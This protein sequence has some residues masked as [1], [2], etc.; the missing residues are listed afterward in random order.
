MVLMSQFCK[1]HTVAR[2]LRFC[3]TAVQ[4][5]LCAFQKDAPYS[6]LLTANYTLYSSISA[7]GSFEID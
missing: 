5:L 6:V 3:S 4:T 1:I 2:Y 7:Y